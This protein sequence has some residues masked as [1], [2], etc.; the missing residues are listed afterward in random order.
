MMKAQ[1]IRCNKISMILMLLLLVCAAYTSAALSAD[2]K[3]V[4]PQPALPSSSKVG[5]PQATLQ[6]FGAYPNL[7][8]ITHEMREKFHPVVKLPKRKKWKKW[9]QKRIKSNNT[10]DADDSN[11]TCNESQIGLMNIYDYI[12]KDY[13]GKNNNDN[14]VILQGGKKVPQLLPTREDALEFAKTQKQSKLFDVGRYD[15]DRRGMYT[16]SLF[17]AK[18]EEQ[19]RTIHVGIDIGVPVGVK[20][21]SFVDGVIH[22]LGY[23]EAIG[24]Y[25]HVIV[26]EHRI[27]ATSKC[28]VLYGH[29]DA[30][31]IK[32]KH[33]G[34]KIKKGEVIGRIGDTS[35][36]GGWT[37][38]HLHFQ[39]AMTP[40]QTH[41]MP[42]V[43]SLKDREGALLEYV[44]PRYV[45]G[46]LY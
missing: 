1:K 41:D 38:T 40:P 21:H 11:N 8:N 33:V 19:R 45:L 36:N 31:S 16:S 18:D 2:T 10:K 28:W 46:E 30:N 43:V 35:E 20:I 3:H 15:E 44:D 22:S 34:Q 39:V 6:A 32:G 5:V 23:N 12:L 14:D 29:L 4:D 37:G 27:S 13:T 42:G 24:D 26:V 9:I 25:G 7:L 17:D